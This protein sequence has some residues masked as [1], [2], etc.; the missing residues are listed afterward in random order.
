MCGSFLPLPASSRVSAISN[1]HPQKVG[2]L[3]RM[4]RS[5]VCIM[6]LGYVGAAMAAAV[7]QARSES[8]EPAFDVIGVDLQTPEG[9]KRIASV[10][11]GLFPFA[12]SDP[13]LHRAIADA[14]ARGNLW[15]TSDADVYKDCDVAVVDVH[16][17]VDIE[18]GRSDFAGLARAIETLGSR[19]KPGA[20]VLVETTVP[21]GTCARVVAPILSEAE[22]KRGL[23]P[24]S[25]LLAHSY[26]RVMPGPD[27]LSSIINYWRVYAGHTPDAAAACR[28]FL[29]RV[30][31]TARYPLT[32]L[33]STT[34]SETA[35]VMENTFRAVTIAL[36]DEWGR[37]AEHAGIDMFSV[38][39]AVR[40]RPT[41]SNLR[42]PGFGV[43]GYCLTK[44]PM[45]GLVAARQLFGIEDADFPLSRAALEINRAM[46]MHALDLVKKA[47]G[48]NL[49][50]RRILLCGVAYR[51]EVADTRYSPSETFLRAAVD[52]GAAVVCHDPHVRYWPETGVDVHEAL[53]PLAGFDAIVFAVDHAAFRGI[54]LP[55][56]LGTE[57]PAIVDANRVF[58]SSS[59]ARLR[60]A[61]HAVVALGRGIG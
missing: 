21:P 51:S 54:D 58:S 14:R 13:D 40:V 45:F 28:R 47:I 11:A 46:P 2:N 57:R 10:N 31:D 35:K 38:V 30:V 20:L 18:R 17:D 32:E 27:Y 53:P 43:G 34:A 52:A 36:M 22:R 12:A 1:V 44:D 37:F 60:E 56:L 23:P 49:A 26:E 6:G 16:L 9:E 8:G 39:D 24:D 4:T 7:A 48:G 3:D 15:A 25:I 61:G 41:H 5:R 50:G 59:L 29:D 42:Q 33:E 19:L 55:A